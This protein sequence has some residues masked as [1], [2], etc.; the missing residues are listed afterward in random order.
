MCGS[1][2]NRYGEGVTGR[3]WIWKMYLLSSLTLL[4]G[5]LKW[6]AFTEDLLMCPYTKYVNCSSCFITRVLTFQS[7]PICLKALWNLEFL[8]SCFLCGLTFPLPESL[9][10][11]LILC[12]GI[13][14]TWL[15]GHGAV[16][17]FTNMPAPGGSEN[18]VFIS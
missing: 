14:S 10:A 17:L 3:L 8:S 13:Q 11:F 5:S 1:N 9:C 2:V 18:S 7:S 4:W 15:N 16:E 12:P 6:P